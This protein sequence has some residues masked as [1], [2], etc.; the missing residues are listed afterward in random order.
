FI[1]E[2]FCETQRNKIFKGYGAII[3]D[4]VLAIPSPAL[5]EN[6]ISPDEKSGEQDQGFVASQA[7]HDRTIGSAFVQSGE[8]ILA[9]QLTM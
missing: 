3:I 6:A 9:T 1:T 2:M 7:A 4:D 8:P 5:S